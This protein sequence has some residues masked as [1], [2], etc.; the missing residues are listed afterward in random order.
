MERLLLYYERRLAFL[1]RYS[2]NFT[3][4]HPRI[5]GCLAMSSDGC[6]NLHIERMIRSF[7]PPVTRVGKRLDDDYSEFTEVPPKMLYPHHLRP[8]PPC[9]V[10]HFSVRGVAA[11][12]NAPVTIACGTFLITH[13]VR[14]IKCRFRTA[15]DVMLVPV[16][17]AV[18]TFERTVPASIA[19]QL[20]KGATG[21]TAIAPEYVGERGGFES[22]PLS[23]LRVYVDGEPSLVA[24]LGGVPFLR[25]TVG[26]VEAERVGVWKRPTSVSLYEVGLIENESLIDYP[27]RS[28]PVYRLSTEH[29]SFA[30]KFNFLD[31]DLTVL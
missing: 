20:L 27:A 23:K 30:E 29:F 5:A 2:R 9:F 28:H 25:M 16:R 12:L 24:T 11:Q 21:S 15:Y 1:C 3:E 26:Y 22:L 19:V 31:I 10:V 4:R 14:K 13:M 6:D 17:I 18:A 7:A 8:F